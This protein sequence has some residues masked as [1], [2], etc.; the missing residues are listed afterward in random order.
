MNAGLVVFLVGLIGDITVAKQVGAPV[1]GVA[2]L[3]GILTFGM[4]LWASNL[5]AAEEA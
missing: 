2:L 4:R 3:L 1:M 5:R